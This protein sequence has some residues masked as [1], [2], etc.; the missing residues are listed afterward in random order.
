MKTIYLL[1]NCRDASDKNACAIWAFTAIAV[2]SS[3]APL[4]K[5]TP[6]TRSALLSFME[7]IHWHSNLREEG[8]KTSDRRMPANFYY[9]PISISFLPMSRMN[10]PNLLV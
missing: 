7:T 1:F 8:K 6:D 9:L 3:I 10:V 4:V 2:T 5:R